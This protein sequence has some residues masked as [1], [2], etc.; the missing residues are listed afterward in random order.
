MNNVIASFAPKN[1]TMAHIMIL[2]NR[3]LCVVGISIF[4]FKKYWQRVFNLME[5]KRT[6]T[7]KQFFQDKTLN[8][9]KKVI[10]S[11]MECEKTES[12]PQEGND[13]TTNL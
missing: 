1:K 3:I 10:L 9:G 4:G 12:L 13:K 2:N 6:P 11:T 7:F 5:I 8:S